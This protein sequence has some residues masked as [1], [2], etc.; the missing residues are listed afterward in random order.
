MDLSILLIF[1]LFENCFAFLLARRTNLLVTSVKQIIYSKDFERQHGYKRL[2]KT[3]DDFTFTDVCHDSAELY[4]VSYI[5]F[6]Y[7]PLPENLKEMKYDPNAP[8]SEALCLFYYHLLNIN[9][10][11]GLVNLCQKSLR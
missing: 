5:I 6:Y 4:A 11:F 9:T 8:I 2:Y 7:V 10:F 3:K 1:L